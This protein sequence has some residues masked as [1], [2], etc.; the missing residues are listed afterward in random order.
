MAK[1]WLSGVIVAIL[2]CTWA[3]G[4]SSSQDAAKPAPAADKDFA[5]K[6]LVISFKSAAQHGA[7]LE[8]AQVKR[9]GDQSFLVG[10]AVDDGQ[11][12]NWQKGRTVWL[13]LGDLAAIVE[14]DDLE[15]LRR[16]MARRDND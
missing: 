3:A 5:G 9:L 6:F 4:P 16:A 11:E 2:F 14:F 1:P 13:A 7:V 8:K 15:Q 12:G 10:K